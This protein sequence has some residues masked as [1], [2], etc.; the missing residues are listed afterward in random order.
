MGSL[1]PNQWAIVEELFDAA[2]K[3]PEAER[4][5][6]LLMHCPDPALRRELVTLLACIGDEG[7]RIASAVSGAALRVATESDPEARL[8]GQHLGP[9]RIESIIGHGGMGAVY[10]AVRDDQQY[11]QQVAIKLVRV[12]AASRTSL[13]RFR[14]E[15][16]IL[17]RLEHSNIARLLD[18]GATEDGVPYLVMEYVEGQ[19]ITKYC[20]ER[21]LAI[22]E[23]LK[24]FLKVCDAIDYAHRNLIVHRDIKPG[25]ILINTPINGAGEPK[26]L[27]FGIAKLL[28]PAAETD[29][30]TQTGM[31]AMTPDYASP[32]QVRGE[33]VST[34]TDVYSLGAVLYEVLTGTRAHRIADYTPAGI[35]EAVCTGEPVRPS[36]AASTSRFRRELEGDLDNIVL[37]AMRKEPERRYRSAADLGADITRH[38]EGRPV[39]ARPDT[40][41]YRAGKF[42]L[43][44][45]YGVIAAALLLLAVGSGAAAT[46]WQARRAE[47]RFQ[48]VRSLANSFIFEVHDKI[49]DLVGSTEARELVVRKGL[50]YLD[51]LAAEA[52]GD[53]ALQMELAS[54]YIKI[55]DVQGNMF[56]PNRGK[57]GEALKSYEKALLIANSLAGAHNNDVA[58]KSLLV[59][60]YLAKGQV[61][62]TAG[63]PEAEQNLREAIRIAESMPPD[64]G[65]LRLELLR[66]AYFAMSRLGHR[67]GALSKEL[68]NA[69]KTLEVS[70]ELMKAEPTDQHLYDRALAAAATASALSNS[71]GIELA[72]TGY[73]ETTKVFAELHQRDPKNST[74]F[75][76]YAGSLALTASLLGDARYANAGD[77]LAGMEYYRRS[78]EVKKQL[79]QNDPGN[80]RRFHDLAEAYCGLGVTSRDRDAKTS[81]E[82]LRQAI[83]WIDSAPASVLDNLWYRTDQAEYIT[84]IAYPLRKLKR[85]EEARRYLDRALLILRDLLVQQPSSNTVKEVLTVALLELFALEEELGHGEA[86]ASAANEALAT[87]K[88]A[89]QAN[90]D[91]VLLTWRLAQSYAALGEL[92]ERR[93]HRKEARRWYARGLDLWKQWKQSGRP[94]SRFLDNQLRAANAAFE[95]VQ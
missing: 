18:G 52:G 40:F 77:T 41:S 82:Y 10:L 69:Q 72:I 16:Q 20:D 8:I 84:S 6:W 53:D 55:G 76:D 79:Y 50:E 94:S 17:A 9:Y 5:Q 51:S 95:R 15:R 58:R 21:N 37:A 48:Q 31:Q 66:S 86:A 74:Y 56:V 32:E 36:A 46:I 45:R 22:R 73:R 91:S 30:A 63:R 44:N 89:A 93:H 7:E 23:R 70:D 24:L 92:E 85:F 13:L 33:A 1:L 87:I 38:L 71:G 67:D 19:P 25:N 34:A 43:R 2:S 12:S 60:V 68:V 75:K 83:D 3:L 59:R 57:Q 61:L 49:A 88:A 35:A 90:P 64:A 80:G 26:L 27:D 29:F 47:R 81:V 54:G 39:S 62:S 4:T 14:Q 42:L 65:V 78:L 11:R 28:D